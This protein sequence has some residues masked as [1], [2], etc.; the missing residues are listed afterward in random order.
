MRLF[1]ARLGIHGT[2]GFMLFAGALIFL[3][4]M[5]LAEFTYPNYNMANNFISDLGDFTHLVPALIFNT[6]I[7]IFG[8]SAVYAGYLLKDS[9]DKRLGVFLMIAGI[10]GA[11]VGIVNEGTILLLHYFFAFTVFIVGGIAIA[12]SVK[13]LYRPPLSYIFIV[14]A[15]I[16]ACLVTLMLINMVFQVHLHLGIGVGGI[17]RMVVFPTIF[18]V[19][20]TGVFLFAQDQYLASSK[21]EKHS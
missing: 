1:N 18:W 20:A 15:G 10:G 9:L 13:V 3:F 5:M 4:G 21:T 16:V 7:V 12:W 11:G 2:A 19:M 17:E 6:T 14:L 8:L